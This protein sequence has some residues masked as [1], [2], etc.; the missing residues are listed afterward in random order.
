VGN[1]KIR[2]LPAKIQAISEWPQPK[3]AH[4]VRQFLG[5]ASY[6]RRYIRDFARTAAPLSDLLVEADEALRKKKF[7]PIHWNARCEDSFKRLKD[8]LTSEPVL[9]QIDEDKKFR[10]ETDCSEWAL[11][12]VLLQIGPD[13]K[14]HPV[15]F[16]GRKLRGAE[17]NYPVY[18][19]ELLVIKYTLR[20]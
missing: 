5:L 1:G 4:E 13:N 12:C 11:G 16:D 7:R 15:A 3:N 20:T 9:Q 6:Y 8:A 10:V 14:W 19:K 18:K 17:L 2:P